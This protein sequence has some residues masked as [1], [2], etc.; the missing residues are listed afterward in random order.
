MQCRTVEPV[1]GHLRHNKRLTCF[2]Q[3]GK[4]RAH[5]QRSLY[6][7]VH[8]IEKLTNHGYAQWT[9]LRAGQH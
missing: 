6:C 4:A 1:F 5:A 7:L 3:R 9:G 2:T 8:N